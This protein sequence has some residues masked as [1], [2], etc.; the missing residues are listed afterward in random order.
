V[1]TIVWRWPSV[2]KSFVMM[3]NGKMCKLN[4]RGGRW[5]L[6]S[7]WRVLFSIFGVEDS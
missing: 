1:A 4:F 2:E 7:E 5:G 6:E 3:E